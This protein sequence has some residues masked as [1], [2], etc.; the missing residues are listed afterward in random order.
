M[1]LS[2]VAVWSDVLAAGG[3]QLIPHRSL[4]SS[5]ITDSQGFLA[6]WFGSEADCSYKCSE[7]DRQTDRQGRID[8]H[9]G[10]SAGH[11]AVRGR[12]LFCR[13]RPPTLPQLIGVP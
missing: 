7:T 2:E 8:V 12:G 13:P 9:A 6:A 3:G 1:L 10:C 5:L 4:G 11:A